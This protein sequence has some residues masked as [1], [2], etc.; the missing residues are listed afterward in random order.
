[1]YRNKQEERDKSPK[2]FMAVKANCDRNASLFEESAVAI[3]MRLFF[4]ETCES[5]SR[6]RCCDRVFFTRNASLFQKALSRTKCEYLSRKR[7]REEEK[8]LKSAVAKS[9]SKKKRCREEEKKIKKRGRELKKFFF[10]SAV[11]HSKSTKKKRCRE[12]QK[13]KKKALS[14]RARGKQTTVRQHL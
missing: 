1:M 10:K 8:F 14:R 4:Q 5:F 9:K 11:A 12:E 6:K 2:L 13:Y 7:C 3:R